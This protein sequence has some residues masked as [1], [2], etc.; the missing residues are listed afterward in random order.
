MGEK[1]GIEL[2]K[3]L[4]LGVFMIVRKGESFEYYDSK[5]LNLI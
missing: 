2:A 3:K 1:K 4:K 5:A